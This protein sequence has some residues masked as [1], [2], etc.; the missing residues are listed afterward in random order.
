MIKQ[1]VHYSPFLSEMEIKITIT[2]DDVN[3]F[4]AEYFKAHPRAKKTL[5]AKPQH[6]SLNEYMTACN[7]K[8]NSSKQNW[9]QFM[10]YLLNEKGLRDIRLD[11]CEVT[12]I[13]YFSNRRKHDLDN[14]TPKF[15]FDG[16]VEGGFLIGDDMSHIT[17]LT[18]MG[19]YDIENP[20]IE[21]IF[22]LP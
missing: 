2:Q 18:I 10:I 3:S 7:M 9:K 22:N 15:I 5:I 13:T 4:N 11:K 20:R 21:L 12:Y 6:P 1:H 17:K 19:G 14:I 16:L 8:S